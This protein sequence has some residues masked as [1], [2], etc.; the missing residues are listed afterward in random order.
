MIIIID[1]KKKKIIIIRMNNN[2]N[3][4]D[5][6]TYSLFWLQFEARMEVVHNNDWTHAN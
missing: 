2:N 3:N 4:N 5:N 1:E 6:N